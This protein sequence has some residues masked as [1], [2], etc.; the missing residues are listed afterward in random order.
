MERD[1]NGITRITGSR[2]YLVISFVEFVFTGH[3][4]R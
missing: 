4:S 1:G 2:V 3:S